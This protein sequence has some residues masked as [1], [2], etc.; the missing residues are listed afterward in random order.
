MHFPAF[1]YERLLLNTSAG[2]SYDAM[3][4]L[5]SLI[6]AV[7]RSQV[8]RTRLPACLEGDATRFSAR[9]CSH[10]Q[11]CSDQ[12]SNSFFFQPDHFISFRIS[13]NHRVLSISRKGAVAEIVV[14]ISC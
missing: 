14:F 12:L 1:R 10:E 6:M 4:L 7:F 13:M 8:K 9:M 11:V 2:A 3:H 5:A